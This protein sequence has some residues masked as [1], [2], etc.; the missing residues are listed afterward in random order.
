MGIG[1]STYVEVTAGGGGSEFGLV[2][3]KDDGTF[4]A[5]TGSTPIG[6]GHITT[7]AMLVADRLGV[8]MEKVEVIYG[9]T[10]VVP[11]G[12][13][14][15]GSRSVQVSGSSMADA[16][17]KLVDAAR[18]VVADLLEASEE[19]IKAQSQKLEKIQPFLEGLRVRKII[20]VPG[21]LINIV[22]N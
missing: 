1:I 12:E 21:K 16:S 18:K 17:E 9:D 8:P 15:G 4:R 10:D 20:F 11:S 14:T 2:E 6:T 3:L 22:V 7:W 5:T 19:D 13:M